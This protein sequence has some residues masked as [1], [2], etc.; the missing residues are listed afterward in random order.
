VVGMTSVPEVV[1]SREAGMCYLSLA[2]VSNFA[3]GLQ[4]QVS[5][6]EVLGIMDKLKQSG[7]NVHTGPHKGHARGK[8]LHMPPRG[9]TF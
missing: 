4:E 1:L 8:T 7:A 9:V 3:A 6:E 2:I 5:H